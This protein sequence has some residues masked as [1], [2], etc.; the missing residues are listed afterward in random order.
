MEWRM[1]FISVFNNKGGVG[2]TTLTFHLANQLAELGHK[3]LLLDADPQCNLSIYCLSE[4]EI[5]RIWEAEDSFID[6]FDR[7]RRRTNQS[8]WSE[9]TKRPRSLHFYLKATEDGTAEIDS[10]PVPVTLRENLDVIVGRLT[11]H[12]FEDTVSSRW[13]GFVSGDPLAL[14]TLTR[15]RNLAQEAART[16]DY[17][18]VITD[19][20]PSLGRLNR[21]IISTADGFL[22]PCTPDLFSLYGIK[23]IGNALGDW[24]KH[25]S[26]VRQVNDEQKLEGFPSNTPR[27]PGLFSVPHEP[28]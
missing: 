9:I 11:L 12:T 28:A 13:N 2:K 26:K 8:E 18:Y 4:E 23:N 5:G 14:R 24:Q 1:K 22:I 3:V 27:C 10:P 17:D 25:F 15:L 7:A 21:L 19:T 6:D 20:S 16:Y